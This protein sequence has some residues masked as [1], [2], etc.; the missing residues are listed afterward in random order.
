MQFL[1]QQVVPSV[2]ALPSVEQPPATT[3]VQ[4]PPTQLPPQ[5]SA[6]AVQAAPSAVQAPAQEPETQE[7]PQHCTDEVQ[8]TPLARQPPPP[9]PPE[10]PVPMAKTQ[11]FEA[12]SQTPTQQSVS[13]AQVPPGEVHDPALMS[14]EPL[15]FVEL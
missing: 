9:V 1:E 2:Q 5:H 4:V 3:G 15:P 13:M 8:A 6:S 10:P 12:G 7:R 11:L 14:V